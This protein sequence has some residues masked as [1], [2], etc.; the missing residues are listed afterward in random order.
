M[1]D[2]GRRLVRAGLLLGVGLGAFVDG[3]LLHQVL[4]THHLVSEVTDDVGTLILADGLLHVGALVA[5]AAGIVGAWRVDRSLPGADRRLLGWVL[6]GWGSFNVADGVVNH[7]LLGIHHIWPAGPGGTLV[8]DLAFLAWG[9]VFVAVG[10]VLVGL[11][12]DR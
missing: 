9:A 1:A 10:C 4:Q 3:I 2:H 6:A 5:T 12:G 8:W 7:H 11:G